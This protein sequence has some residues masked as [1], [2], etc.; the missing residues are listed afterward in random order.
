MQGKYYAAIDIG[1]NAVR[2]LIKEATPSPDHTVCHLNKALL[3]RVPLRLGFDVFTSGAISPAK[4]KDL[5]RLIKSFRHLLHI[6]SVCSYRAC[7]TSAMRDSSN[8]KEII[9]KIKKATS[10][11]IEIIDGQEEASLIYLNHIDLAEASA[12][13]YMFVDVGGGST[14]LNLLAGGQLLHSSSFNIGTVRMLSGAVHDSTWQQLETTLRQISSSLPD[15]NIIGS[16]GNINKLFRLATTKKNKHTQQLPVSSLQTIYSQLL[17]LTPLQRQHQF[18][19]KPDRADVIVPAAEI[20]LRIASILHS[21]Y[22][23]V[24]VIGLADGIIDALYAEDTAP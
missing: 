2:L 5:C 16:G 11:D 7:A 4:A 19:L 23:S 15:I 13:N 21:Q 8:G 1:S 18:N 10:I 6:Y 24:P 3:V 22:I 20:F 9:K 12:G 17:P 14:E